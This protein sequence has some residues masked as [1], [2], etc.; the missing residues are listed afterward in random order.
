M[1]EPESRSL[2]TIYMWVLSHNFFGILIFD[3][4]LKIVLKKRPNPE[5]P[6]FFSQDGKFLLFFTDCY[7]VSLR[8]EFVP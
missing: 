3:P 8:K 6:K 5:I 7:I 1:K 2:F 4:K